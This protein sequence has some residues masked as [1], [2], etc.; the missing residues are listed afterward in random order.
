MRAAQDF[1]NAA[2]Q[3]QMG[4]VA[5][6]RM[7]VMREETNQVAQ[8]WNVASQYVDRYSVADRGHMEQVRRQLTTALIDLQAMIS[9]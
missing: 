8:R 3:L 2:R 1:R 7:D 9:L 5:G 6:H 4:I